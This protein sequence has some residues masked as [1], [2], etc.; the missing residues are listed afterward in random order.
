VGPWQLPQSGVLLARVNSRPS[1]GLEEREIGFVMAVVTQIVA[2]VPA[3]PHHNITVF[4]RDDE[5]VMF[6]KRRG[7]GL[8]RFVTGIAVEV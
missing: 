1:R 5:G 2:V 6:V 7:G 8:F 3:V 4:P